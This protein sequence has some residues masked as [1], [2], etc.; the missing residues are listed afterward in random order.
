MNSVKIYEGPSMLDGKPIVVF[1]SGLGGS[2][3]RKTGDAV[4][5]WIMRSDIEPHEAVKTGADVSVCGDCVHRPMLYKDAEQSPCYVKTF[6]A[7]L[8]IYR[9]WLRGTVKSVTLNEACMLVDGR[10]LRLGAYGDPA[11]VPREAIDAL[12]SWAGDIL[13][14]THQWK[15]TRFDW[16]KAYC[17]ASVDNAVEH[18]KARAMGWRSFFVIPRGL[19]I[20]PER[21]VQCPASKEMGAKTSCIACRACGGLSAKAKVDIAI[22]AH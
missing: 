5:M 11:A 7:P 22:N 13:G 14:Y 1:L 18:I 16:L 12:C 21:T 15:D 19:E 8:S 20:K 4:Q 2:R 3:N 10:V 9:A 17:M 6:Q